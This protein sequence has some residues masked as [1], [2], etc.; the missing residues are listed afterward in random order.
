MAKLDTLVTDAIAEHVLEPV[1]LQAP[2]QAWL[3]LSKTAVDQGATALK[4]ARRRLI[5][6]N[7]ESTNVIKLVRT[8]IRAAHDPQIAT[9]IENSATQKRSILADIALLERQVDGSNRPVTPKNLKDLGNLIR[10]KLTDV[11]ELPNRRAYV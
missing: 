5:M 7:G 8:G 1:R 2:L 3:D 9:E 4:D 11:N 10:R 6:L